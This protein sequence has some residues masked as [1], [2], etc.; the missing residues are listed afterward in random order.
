V[1]RRRRNKDGILS[2]WRAAI[3]RDQ[4]EIHRFAVQAA[5]LR[6]REELRGKVAGPVD[7]EEVRQLEIQLAQV[8]D[9]AKKF[10]ALPVKKRRLLDRLVERLW[11]WATRER[12][13]RPG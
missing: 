5:L 1:A 2:H 12:F 9:A 3:G 7:F 13:S 8:A 11:F 6:K 10:S 4:I